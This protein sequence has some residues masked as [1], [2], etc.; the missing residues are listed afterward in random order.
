MVARHQ[1][2]L[3][4]LHR[5]AQRGEDRPRRR[6]R[7][8]LGA[9]AQLDDVAEQ[10]QAVDPVERRDERGQA[11][12]VGA[13]DVAPPAGAEVQVGDDE[14]AQGPSAGGRRHGLADRLGSMKRTSSWTTWNSLT[15]STPRA[16]KKS[17]S[18]VT[19]SSGALAPDEIPTTRLPSSHSSRTW[20]ALSIR[21]ASSAP[22]SRA[23]STSRCEFEEFC[24]P[25]TSTRSQRAAIC[26]TAA[27]RLV[28]A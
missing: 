19:S 11:G 25:I 21:Y 12:R 26:L 8:A 23:T 16:R 14:G 15:S 4:A 7:L 3:P 6:E 20:P 18:A 10:H 1:H 28:V 24:E 27:W 22:C 17:T 13:Q 2:D 5:G 9:V